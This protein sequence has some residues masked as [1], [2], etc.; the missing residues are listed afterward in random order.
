MPKSVYS[1]KTSTAICSRIA[2][3]ESL[4][5]ICKDPAMPGMQTVQDWLAAAAQGREKYQQFCTD[6]TIARQHWADATFTEMV[7]LAENCPLDREPIAKTR[8]VI[9]TMKWVLARMN[10]R[11]Y[12]NRIDLTSQG[13][14]LPPPAIL[15]EIVNAPQEVGVMGNPG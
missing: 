12:G 9:D 1:Q 7:E 13:E 6:Y 4:T 3:G 15:V 5:A 14:Q 2:Q 8:L 10:P 11:K